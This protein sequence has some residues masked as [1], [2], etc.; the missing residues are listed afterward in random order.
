MRRAAAAIKPGGVQFPAFD[1]PSV[2][3]TGLVPVIHVFLSFWLAKTW[4]AG[5]SPAMTS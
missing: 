1:G 4:M 5:S 2:V 3:I